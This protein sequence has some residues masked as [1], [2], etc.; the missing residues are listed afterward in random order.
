MSGEECLVHFHAEAGLLQGQHA[1]VRAHTERFAHELVAEEIE[2]R[3]VRLEV[4]RVVDGGEDVDAGGHVEPRHRRVGMDGQL[5]RAGQRGDA[6]TL[7]DAARLREIRLE[8]G[9]DAILDD[10]RELEAGVVILPRGQGQAAEA[11]CLSIARVV[12]RGEGLL[13]PADAVGIEA[14]HG[15]PGI[16]DGVTGVGV[17]E[18]D[19]VVAEG[20]AHGGHAFEVSRRRVAHAELEGL[21][22]LGHERARLLHEGARL[23]IAE[24]DAPRVGGHGTRGAT[25]EAVERPA[26]GFAADVPERH[27]EAAHGDGGGRAHAVRAELHLVDPRPHAD[28][29]G[30]I[31]AE[32]ELA[33]RGVRVVSDRARGAAMMGLTPAHEAVVRGDPDHHGVALH[34]LADAEGHARAG[35]HGE[36]GRIGLDVGDFHGR[37]SPGKTAQQFMYFELTSDLTRPSL[38]KT[39]RCSPAR[40]LPYTWISSVSFVVGLSMAWISS[41]GGMRTDTAPGLWRSTLRTSSWTVPPMSRGPAEV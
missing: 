40:S 8:D 4:T 15:A 28:H 18:D 14:G 6:E 13:Q 24:G 41:W 29:V 31:H 39:W 9:D 11:P 30:G 37:P 3:D 33:Q 32:D 5:P 26:G 36:R 17:G 1:A 7:R 38:S 35:R 34:G 27:V 10:A 19:H 23:L 16:D 20:L 2:L 21:V 12:V 22:A 25:Q